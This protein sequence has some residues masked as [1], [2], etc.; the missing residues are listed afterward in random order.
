MKS[1][2]KESMAALGYFALL[3]AVTL[4]LVAAWMNGFDRYWDLVVLWLYL[5]LPILAACLAGGL[6]LGVAQGLWRR[7]SGRQPGRR[8]TAA[9]AIALALCGLVMFLLLSKVRADWWYLDIYPWVES[10]AGMLVVVALSLIGILIVGALV[11]LAALKLLPRAIAVLDPVRPRMWMLTLLAAQVLFL[12]STFVLS[13]PEAQR[14]EVLPARAGEPSGAGSKVVLLGIDGIASRV[15]D[16]M[17]ADGEL[18]NFRKLIDR[19]IYAPLETSKPTNSP[20]LWTTIATGVE[21]DKHGIANFLVQHPKGMGRPVVTLPSHMGLN[22]TFLLRRFYGGER[23]ATYPVTAAL[24][25]SAAVWDIAGAYGLTVGVV[26]WWPS[27]SVTQVNGFMISDQASEY[28]RLRAREGW[29]G[30][31]DDR[32]GPL[33]REGMTYPEQLL[34]ELESWCRARECEALGDEGLVDVSLDLYGRLSPDLLLLYLKGPDPAQHQYWDA[35]EPHLFREVAA[36]RIEKF[37]DAIPDV[38]RR[39]D[40][41]LGELVAG[42]GEDVNLIIVSDHGA[43]PVFGLL[44][45]RE[46]TGGHEHAPPGVIIAVGPA[47]EPGTKPEGASILDVAPTIQRILGLPLARDLDGRVLTE[48]LRP[49]TGETTLVDSW[50]YLVAGETAEADPEISKEQEK[51]LKALGYL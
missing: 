24:R 30:G 51:L 35:Y 1:A 34:G 32:R 10:W 23:V 6:A 49:L 26:N 46:F 38:Y 44:T 11:F 48:M 25:S 20:V 21:R 7:L 36:E 9:L 12:G 50:N 8:T 29:S 17:L 14:P 15:L 22:T 33:R 41:L 18:P 13:K 2:I 47:F 45:Y 16:P 4:T 37:G 39:T 42:I 43:S 40:R 28:I 5:Q 19:G 27:W 3:T 31:P